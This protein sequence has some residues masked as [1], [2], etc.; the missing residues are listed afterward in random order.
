MIDPALL[1][2]LAATPLL[3][4]LSCSVQG[5]HLLLLLSFWCVFRCDLLVTGFK[6]SAQMCWVLSLATLISVFVCITGDTN[7]GGGEGGIY[8][9]WHRSRQQQK[10]ACAC[11]SP[12]SL[13]F[14]C[15]TACRAAADWPSGWLMDEVFVQVAVLMLTGCS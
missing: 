11:N 15:H 6:N 8:G 14:S 12:D 9:Q 3:D 13:L 2:G 10:G 1:I 7:L 4:M 5:E